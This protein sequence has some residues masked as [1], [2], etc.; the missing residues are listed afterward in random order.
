M[1]KL[2]ILGLCLWSVMFVNGQQITYQYSYDLA[3]NRTRSVVVQIN[4][5]GD[6]EDNLDPLLNPFP[7]V[8]SNGLT[9]MV[10]PNPTKENV[11]FELSGDNKIGDYVLSDITGRVI[12][13]GHC[14]NSTLSI[15]LFGQDEGIYLFEVFIEKKPYIYKIIKQ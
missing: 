7:D 12:A 14:E 8:L 10:Y 6:N 3:G 11:R 9:M 5:G 15:D 4:K 1:K 2:L 13:K